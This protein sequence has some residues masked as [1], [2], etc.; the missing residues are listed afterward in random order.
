MTPFGTKVETYLRMV[1]LPYETKIGDPRRNPK[2]KVP[3]VVDD[4]RMISDSSD[5]VDHL[6]AKYGDPLDAALTPAQRALAVTVRRTIEEHLYWALV[7]TRWVEPDGYVRTR[8]CLVKLLPPV[9]GGVVVDRVIRRQMLGQ[10]RAHGLGRHAPGDVYRRGCEDLSA[11]AALLG[12]QPY[13]L[14]ERPTTVDASLYAMG[15]GIWMFPA[16]SPLKRHFG[17]HAN[18][19]AYVERMHGRYFGDHPPG[20]S[21]PA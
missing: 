12:E 16:D 6:K 2:G 5:I 11:I 3:W 15:A 17:G 1:G 8:E 7:H 20:A 13:L 14:G 9:L 10:L 19:V 21:K 18:L 4:G